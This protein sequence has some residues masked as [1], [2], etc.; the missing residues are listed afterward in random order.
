MSSLTL[1]LNDP[2]F[3]LDVPNALYVTGASI[4]GELLLDYPRALN[5]NVERVCVELQGFIRT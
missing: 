3:E 2:A 4:R 1:T 5:E